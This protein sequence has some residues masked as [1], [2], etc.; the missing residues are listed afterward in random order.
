M[1]GA[2]GLAL[3]PAGDGELSA[4]ARVEVELL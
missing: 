1:L 3:V 2:H 4:G